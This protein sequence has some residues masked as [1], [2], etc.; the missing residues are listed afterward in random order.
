MLLLLVM[1]VMAAVLRGV[2]V[3]LEL[4]EGSGVEVEGCFDL[5]ESGG[6]FDGE[7]DEEEEEEEEVEEVGEGAREIPL[8]DCHE[9]IA[10]CWS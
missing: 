1:V 5:G 4:G 6:V 2:E 8:A 10:S 7:D 9:A 3:L